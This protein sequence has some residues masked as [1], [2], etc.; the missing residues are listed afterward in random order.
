MSRV[1][2][3]A[4]PFRWDVI[5]PFESSS[6]RPSRVR[7]MERNWYSSRLPSIATLRPRSASRLVGWRRTIGVRRTPMAGFPKHIAC[8]GFLRTLPDGVPENRLTGWHR[9]RPGIPA[10]RYRF[11][12]RQRLPFRKAQEELPDV[13]AEVLSVDEL[14]PVLAVVDDRPRARV[15]LDAVVLDARKDRGAVPRDLDVPRRDSLRA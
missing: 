8:Y 2:R 15:E 1:V 5:R 3:K 10:G 6:G 14:A 12:Q 9:K 11:E 4:I 7:M 13:F